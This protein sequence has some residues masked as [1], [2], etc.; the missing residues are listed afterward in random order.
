MKIAWVCNTLIP[1]VAEKANLVLNKPESWISGLHSLFLNQKDLT[2]T[3]YFPNN[4]P[5]KLK[6][7]NFYYLSFPSIDSKRECKKTYDFFFKAFAIDPPDVVHVFGT[8]FPHTLS[9][10][11]ACQALGIK[12]RCVIHIQGLVSFCALHNS[13]RLPFSV[14]YGVSFRDFLKNDSVYKQNIKFK[15][16]GKFETKA[17]LMTQ[18]VI[19]RTDWDKSIVRKLNPDCNYHFCNE[20]LRNNF[21]NNHWSINNC[22]RHSVFVSQS[23]Y[24]LKGFHVVLES[25]YAVKKVFPDVKVYTTGKNILDKRMLSRIKLTRYQQYLVKLIKKYK[26]EN[27]VVFLGYLNEKKMCERMCK[28]H[29]FVLSSFLE[30]SSNSLGESMMVGTPSISSYVGGVSSIFRDKIDGYCYPCDEPELLSYYIEK[31]FNDDSI[32]LSFSDSSRK[33]A[34]ATHDKEAIYK[35]LID[36]YAKISSL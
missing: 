17:L 21:Y 35:N 20:V 9:V 18:N 11:K 14:K 24:S 1:E 36:I 13:I 19:G 4:T 26:L 8:E 16:R 12:K 5:L 31:I 32:A 6:E 25:I 27:S 30:N 10:L 7:K 28:S 34:M 23:N 22:E 29:V 15:K 2:I 33:H 3:Y